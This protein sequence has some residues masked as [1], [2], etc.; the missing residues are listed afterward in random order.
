MEDRVAGRRRRGGNPREVSRDGA[1][2]ARPQPLADGGE[3]CDLRGTYAAGIRLSRAGTRQHRCIARRSDR[4]RPGRRHRTVTT[5]G[6]R[7]VTTMALEAA[8]QTGTLATLPAGALLL[9][10]FVDLHVH[11]P[12]YP[13]LGR[14]LDVP[15]EVWL[16]KYTFPLEAR[17][18]DAAFARRV[19]RPVG[20]R[21]ASPAARP[22]RS[23]SPPIHDEATCTPC[24]HLPGR[25]A[26]RADRQGGDG[27]SGILP[28]LLS[29]RLAGR[30]RR[31]HACADRLYPRPSRQ[32]AT[33][34]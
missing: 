34:A 31:G 29:R 15:L 26:A 18:A 2:A 3:T 21:P 8:R 20:R 28:R 24:R 22:P 33:A 4:D 19:Y 7:P 17:Y 1:G 23:I 32:R 12:Q 6:V 16:H 10:G 13:Q 27:R 30:R 25:G 11:A 9:P 14:A 5:A